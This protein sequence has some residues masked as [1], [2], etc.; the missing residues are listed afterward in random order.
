MNKDLYHRKAKLPES[1]KTHLQKSFEMVEGDSNIEGYNRNKDLREKGVIGYPVL[2]RIKNWF[3]SYDGD[4]KDLPFVLNG[5][6]RMHKWCDHV[7]NHWRDR[8]SQGKTVKSDTGMDNQFIDNHEK[9]GIIVNSHD[10]H[11]KGIN[12]FD[13]SITEEIKKINKLFKTIE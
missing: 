13:T 2:K 6:H 1:L 11:E 3:D 10:K 7:L 12:K 4:G 5:G 9:E 8:M